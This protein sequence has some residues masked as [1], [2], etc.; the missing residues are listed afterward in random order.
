MTNDEESLLNSFIMTDQ[1][2]DVSSLTSRSQRSGNNYTAL[3][4]LK[5][6]QKKIS[7]E[8]SEGEQA[9]CDELEDP[10]DV[11]FEMETV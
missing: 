11:N 1:D 9:D 6:K 5:F 4:Y 2:A 3:N 7:N 10:K 8:D